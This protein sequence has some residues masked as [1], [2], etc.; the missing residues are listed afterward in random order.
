MGYVQ[1]RKEL[2]VQIALKDVWSLTD[3][4]LMLMAFPEFG[5]LFIFA[6]KHSHV[7]LSI[8]FRREDPRKSTFATVDSSFWHNRDD[9]ISNNSWTSE[10]PQPQWHVFRQ[11]RHLFGLF[12]RILSGWHEC[13]LWLNSTRLVIGQC[14]RYSKDLRFNHIET[15]TCSHSHCVAMIISLVGCVMYNFVFGCALFVLSM[16]V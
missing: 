6:L 1:V 9:V 16:Y 8:Y 2:Q 7:D 12:E 10:Q 13:S 4:K 5:L 15:C 3:D 11:H 14:Q